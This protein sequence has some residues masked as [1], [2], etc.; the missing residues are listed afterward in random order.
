[1]MTLPQDAAATSNTGKNRTLLFPCIFFC[2]TVAG[3]KRKWIT[4]LVFVFAALAMSIGYARYKKART[5][6]PYEL[7]SGDIV[8][9]ETNGNQAMAVKAATNS[10]WSHVGMVFHRNGKPMVIEAVQPVRVTSLASF[11]ARNPKS[12]YAMR[13]KNADDKINAAA[14]RRAEQ[15]CNKLLGKDYDSRFRWSDDQIYCSELVWKVYKNAVG[16]ELCKPRSFK[17]YNLKHP[18]VRRLVKARYGSSSNLPLDEIAVAPS[19]LAES[20]LLTEVPKKVKK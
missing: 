20:D 15:Y 13:L 6:N 1:M 12:F 3:M 2:V 18:T 7:R 9:Q 16:I 17:S 11:I 4:L 5:H 19:D 10:H 14:I 8:F